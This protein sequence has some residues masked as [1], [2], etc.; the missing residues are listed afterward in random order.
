MELPPPLLLGMGAVLGAGL[1]AASY[2]DLRYREIPDSLWL[3][4]GLV[5]LLGGAWRASV[6]GWVPV[7]LWIVVGLLVLE[8]LLPWDR[9][10]PSR[11][12]QGSRW[13]EPSAYLFVGAL[14]LGVGITPDL[15]GVSGAFWSA[16]AVYL[17]VL[18]A[19]G[20]FEARIF[21]GGAD[22]KCL[23]IVA[24]FLPLWSTP[25]LPST[26]T[27]VA[28]LGALPFSVTVLLNAWVLS[29]LVP[30][31]LGVRNLIR[32]DFPKGRGFRGYRLAVAELPERFVWVDDPDRKTSTLDA[33]VESSEGDLQLRLDLRAQLESEGVRD[34]WVTPQI[35]FVALLSVGTLVGVAAGGLV[36]LLWG[37]L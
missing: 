1:A 17:S 27:A 33:D 6:A 12:A 19:R 36:F 37:W 23:M 5:G 16:G 15:G 14:L 7:L 30:L 3:G 4:L 34:L 18:L 32:H 35:P 28:L 13:I 21:G 11:W 22:S 8:H 10:V 2:F 20:L 31:Y 9:I 26:A 24:L 29:L 25:W